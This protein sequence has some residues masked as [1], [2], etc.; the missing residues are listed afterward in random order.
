M[1][2]TAL[3]KV[4]YYFILAITTPLRALSDVVLSSN[5]TDAIATANGYYGALN[6]L[7]PVDTMIQILGISLLFESL[8]LIYKIIMWVVKKIPMIN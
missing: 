6:T 5:F 2:I 7:L 3:L 4:V 8:Y 1:I